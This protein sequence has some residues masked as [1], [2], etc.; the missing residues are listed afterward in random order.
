MQR[1]ETVQSKANLLGY[2]V[3]M[4][5]KHTNQNERNHR[6]KRLLNVQGK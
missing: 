5:L 6:A 2:Q 4:P 1:E 3:K